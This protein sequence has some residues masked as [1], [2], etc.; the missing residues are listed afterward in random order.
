MVMC[1]IDVQFWFQIV[2]LMVNNVR[3]MVS[4]LSSLSSLRSVS[5]QANSVSINVMVHY[6]PIGQLMEIIWEID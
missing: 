4:R 6:P 2:L 1:S 3:G 5:L